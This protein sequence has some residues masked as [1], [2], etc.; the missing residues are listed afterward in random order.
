MAY[1]HR[2]DRRHDVNKGEKL[3]ERI[4]RVLDKELWDRRFE[5]VDLTAKEP[6]KPKLEEFEVGDYFLV[7]GWQIVKVEEKLSESK[8][9][10]RGVT[11]GVGAKKLP[12]DLAQ[13]IDR[14]LTENG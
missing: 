11:Y 5:M 6:P 14:F 3:P 1:N 7:G 12:N 10:S 9:S 8:F 2:L 4:D 13:Q